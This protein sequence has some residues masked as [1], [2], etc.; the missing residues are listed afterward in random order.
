MKNS[1]GVRATLGVPTHW[2]PD[3]SRPFGSRIEESCSQC[4]IFH[5]ALVVLRFQHADAMRPLH[6]VIVPRGLLFDAVIHR[7]QL[8][9]L[10]P[11]ARFQYRDFRLRVLQRQLCISRLFLCKVDGFLQGITF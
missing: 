7:L 5:E 4:A 2:A 11:N 3:S 6:V 1:G 9:F 8:G 10:H